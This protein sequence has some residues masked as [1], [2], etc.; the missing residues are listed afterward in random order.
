MEKK[1]RNGSE[2]GQKLKVSHW[3]DNYLIKLERI[4][5]ILNPSSSVT[6][7]DPALWVAKHEEPQNRR[8]QV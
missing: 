4:S 3:H 8:V 2:L 5:W 1:P 7:D 6:I